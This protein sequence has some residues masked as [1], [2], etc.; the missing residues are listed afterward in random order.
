MDRRDSLNTAPP[1]RGIS[2]DRLPLAVGTF[3][4]AAVVFSAAIAVTSPDNRDSSLT[5]A[6]YGFTTSIPL[7]VLAYVWSAVDQR[8]RRA[9]TLIFFLGAWAT[10]FGISSAI[11]HFDPTAGTF[12]YILCALAF[13]VIVVVVIGG[14]S[15]E[16]ER[17][18][19][20]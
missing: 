10:I 16:R 17:D 11:Q 5:N 1:A 13:A 2:L 8:A 20:Y 7:I 14:A 9:P 12:F 18:Q 6:L 19:R 15:R 3:I 4:G